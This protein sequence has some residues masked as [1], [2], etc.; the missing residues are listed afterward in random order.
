MHDLSDCWPRMKKKKHKTMSDRK[1]SDQ[2]ITN[3]ETVNRRAWIEK[4]LSV[5]KGKVKDGAETVDAG[6]QSGKPN[7][8]IVNTKPPR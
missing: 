2:L 1:H 5:V 6:E 3:E 7:L 8:Y 4:A